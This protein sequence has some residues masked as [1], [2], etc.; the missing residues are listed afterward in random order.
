MKRCL[1]KQL[2]DKITFD[3]MS[4]DKTSLFDFWQNVVWWKV[5]WQKVVWQIDVHSTQQIKTLPYNIPN[6]RKMFQMTV[7]YIIIFHFKAL[8]NLPKLEFLVFWQ[9]WARRWVVLMRF[10]P[11]VCAFRFPLNPYLWI[12]NSIFIQICEYHINFHSNLWNSSLLKRKPE[13]GSQI[14]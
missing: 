2:F 3:K 9:H 11:C 12:S 1:T 4:F 6:D 10:N 13:A 8:Q 5:I 7:K 14:H